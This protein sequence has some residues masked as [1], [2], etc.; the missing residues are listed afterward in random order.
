MLNSNIKE[1]G[2]VRAESPATWDAGRRSRIRNDRR[3]C[4]FSFTLI[5]L[6]VFS[7]CT[8]P[9]AAL[10]PKF[11]GVLRIAIP[12]R[13]QRLD[14]T[15][16]TQDY[17][18]MVAGCLFDTLVAPGPGG[19][20]MPV[21][22]DVMPEKSDDGLTYY[23]KLREG[24]KFHDGSPVDAADVLHSFKRL[25]KNRRS[26]YSW[27]LKDVE[28]AEE[29]R[30]GKLNTITGFKLSDALRFEIR[31]KQRRPEFI[32]YLCFPALSIVPTADR[33]FRPPVGTGPFK[34]V[35]TPDKNRLTLAAN[36][37]YFRGRPYADAIVFRVIGDERDRLTELKRGE[38][39][40]AAV[41]E[42]GLSKSESEIFG[43]AVQCLMER[44]YF[45]DVN[46]KYAALTL[47][48][49]RIA[50]SKSIDREEIVKVF[51]SGNGSIENNVPGAGDPR[52][53][54]KSAMAGTTLMLWNPDRSPGMKLISKKLQQDFE[55]AGVSLKLVSRPSGGMQDYSP[56]DAP[57][58][59][60]RSLPVL[61]GLQDSV[62][63]PLFSAGQAAVTA[64]MERRIGDLHEDDGRVPV[65]A[66]INLFSQK[67][68]Y[69]KREGVRGLAPGPFGYPAF[70][71]VFLREP[72]KEKPEEDKTEKEKTKK[73][74]K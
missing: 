10:P 68:S 65:G 17:E 2:R 71:S 57:A 64:S 41:P 48:G 4:F 62:E 42:G 16:L 54:R 32:K 69:I 44:L 3:R 49:Q 6:F 50:L 45:I 1:N 38:V 73:K 18:M 63:K 19:G 60:L 27:L 28:G 70:D 53:L 37:E 21:L 52:A 5:A 34:Y 8:V 9:Q 66:V 72:V 26:P 24:L 13:V 74:S 67:P 12:E 59:I 20:Y 30:E 31:L 61:M 22:L 36:N 58:F 46:T 39:D 47:P 23:F 40:I 14:P 33:N 7:I 56:K 51:L 55:R 11:G 43:P 15:Q 29:F 35:E 25:M